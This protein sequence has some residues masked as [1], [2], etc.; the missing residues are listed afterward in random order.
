MSQDL[1]DC[2]SFM[3]I[4]L[5]S[6]F[7]AQGISFIQDQLGHENLLARILAPL[8][9]VAVWIW[10]LSLGVSIFLLLR[11]NLGKYF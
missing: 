1:K 6:G 10:F 2:I 9:K 11:E 7:V 3:A 8:G 5:A 4:A